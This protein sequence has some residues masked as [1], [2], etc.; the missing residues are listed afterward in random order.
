MSFQWT[1]GTTACIPDKTVGTNTVRTLSAILVKSSAE[2]DGDVVVGSDDECIEVDDNVGDEDVRGN[3]SES[4]VDAMV[5]VDDTSG[6]GGWVGWVEVDA[7]KNVCPSFI[8][9]D[10]QRNST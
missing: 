6:G 5:G 7:E 10:S 2:N 3:G 8:F 1:V 4:E 9:S